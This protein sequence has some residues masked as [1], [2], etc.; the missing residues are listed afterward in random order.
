MKSI[1]L[2]IISFIIYLHYVPNSYA[3]V[4]DI[5]YESL[6]EEFIDI[7]PDENKNIYV[8][9]Y[10]IERDA[11]TFLFKKGK[12]ILCKPIGGK[13]RAIIYIGDGEFTLTPPTQIEKEQLR[14]FYDSYTFKKDFKFLLIIFADETLKELTNS[15]QVESGNI[16]S[17]TIDHLYYAKKYFIND[18]RKIINSEFMKT[19]L[20]NYSNGLFYAY[21]FEKKGDPHIFEINPFKLEEIRLSKRMDIS[22]VYYFTETVTQFH[23]ASD[24]SNFGNLLGNEMKDEYEIKKIT[25]DCEIRPDGNMIAEA[26]LKIFPFKFNSRWLNLHLYKK[27]QVDSVIWENQKNKPYFYKG[28]NSSILWIKIPDNIKISSA[29]ILNIYYNGEILKEEAGVFIL[30]S[31]TAWYPHNNRKKKTEFDITYHTPV[32]YI[33]VSVGDLVY[34]KIDDANQIKTTRW[35]TQKPIRNASFNF[36]LYTTNTIEKTDIPKIDIY[37]TEFRQFSLEGYYSYRKIRKAENYNE[38]IADIVSDCVSFFTKI[39]GPLDETNIK[40]MEIP[41]GHSEAFAGMVH[42]SDRS[43]IRFK[44]TTYQEYVIAHEIA[45]Q[46]WGVGVDY[47]TYHDKWLSEAFASYSAMYYIEKLFKSSNELFNRLNAWSNQ[48]VENRVY[49]L[50]NGQ[51]AGPIWLGWRTESSRTYDDY[52]LII[53]QKGAWILHMLRN[54]MT[55]FKT[56][57][58]SH[59]E[60]M[61]KEYYSKFEGKN[62]TTENFK[63]IVDKYMGKDMNWFFDQWVYGTDIPTYYVSIDHEKTENNDYVINYIIKQSNVKHDFKMPVPISIDFGSNRFAVVEILVT[64]LVTEGQIPNIPLEPKKITFNALNSVLCKIEYD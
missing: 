31:S 52:S 55:D 28:E 21:F 17:G 1:F 14:R 36:G 13:C 2:A 24:Y 22:H 57:D 63:K 32:K 60:K 6:Y 18:D 47:K 20:E 34:K 16:P 4:L 25:L 38:R 43:F 40:V 39:F 62:S 29:S 26:E 58:S 19:F 33:L 45:H 54:L 15:H 64:G 59:F 49:F 37:T 35:V 53:Y 46:W 8:E 9:N 7:E 12:F 10:K 50:G 23:K 5:N 56:Y 3:Q 48:I 51:K 30:K 27:I 11:A 44:G 42:L 61:L 41:H